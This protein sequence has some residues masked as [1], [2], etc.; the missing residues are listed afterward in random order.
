VLYAQIF[1]ATMG[2]AI[3]IE[4]GGLGIGLL[5]LIGGLS[6]IRM[7]RYWPVILAPAALPLACGA[8]LIAVQV[9]V[10]G[11]SIGGGYGRDFIPWMASVVIMQY[12]A[13]RPG[14]L[15]RLSIVVFLI[16][17]SCVPFMR[18]FVNDASRV[19]LS[20][21]ITIGN[22]NDFGAWFGFCCVYFTVLGLEVRRNWV[23]VV[24]WLVALFCLFIVGVTVSRAPLFAMAC[25]LSFALRRVLKH[26]FFPIL[27]LIV[28]VW[29]VY[30]LGYFDGPA[31]AYAQRGLEET[32][33]LQVWP[34][35]IRRFLEAPL[36]GVGLQH[37]KTFIPIADMAIEPHNGAI[38]IALSSGIVPLVFFVAYWVQLVATSMRVG[39]RSHPDAPFQ[40]A[41]L[42]YSFLISMN[43]NTAFML[44]WMMGTFASITAADFLWKARQSVADQAV[45]IPTSRSE[46]LQVRVRR[47]PA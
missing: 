34:L 23:R 39:V 3:G 31:A 9:V 21:G 45:G 20:K 19:G 29:I 28:L 24:A 6:V 25:S 33:R 37:T 44:P 36:T 1:Y 18:S 43:L 35:A 14:F 2:P 26:G 47:S 46:R 17:L 22:P 12:L 10:F 40:S 11:D 8:S 38:F 7:S 15:H 4:I 41:L 42:I 32:G 30:A 16:G 13:L 5:A 27:A